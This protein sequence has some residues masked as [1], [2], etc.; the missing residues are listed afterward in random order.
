KASKS[1][2]DDDDDSG[3]SKG[4][5]DGEP[6]VTDDD[7]DGDSAE[8]SRPTARVNEKTVVYSERDKESDQAFVAKPSMTLYPTETKGK[9]TL[10]ETDDGDSGWL[11]TSQIDV[12]E[13]GGGGARKREI[14]VRAR[15]GVTFMQ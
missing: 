15:L 9:W 8:E 6:K 3:S 7:K 12:D 13:G 14:D 2:G 1:S 5:D 11:L 4:G 10:V